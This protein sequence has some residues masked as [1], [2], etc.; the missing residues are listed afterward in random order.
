MLINDI[1]IKLLGVGLDKLPRGRG[2]VKG[3]LNGVSYYPI[4]LFLH[5][6]PFRVPTDG[7][8]AQRNGQGCFRFPPLAQI[9]DLKTAILLINKPAFVYDHAGIEFAGQ[10][11]GQN[12]IKSGYDNI[13]LC[14]TG[15]IYYGG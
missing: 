14:R 15:N 10:Y 13:V 5:F 12:I 4:N 8:T 3:V 1:I 6:H 7:D 9:N 2:I 11:S